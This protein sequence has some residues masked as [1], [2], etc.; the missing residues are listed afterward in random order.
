M[1]SEPPHRSDDKEGLAPGGDGLGEE[2]IGRLVGEILLTG[3]EPDERPA[4]ARR[5]VSDRP[6]EH[7]VPRLEGVED[8]ALGGGAVDLQLHLAAD[9]GEGPQMGR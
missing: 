7:R 3:E 5:G 9:L 4:L 2:G 1:S 6:A 8:E